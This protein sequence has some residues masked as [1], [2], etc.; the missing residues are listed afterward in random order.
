MSRRYSPNHPAVIAAR[1]RQDRGRV[2]RPGR[3]PHRT[4]MVTGV[5]FTVA[6]FL[7]IDSWWGLLSAALAAVFLA[8]SLAG[9]AD[10][11]DD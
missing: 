11:L 4:Y 7:L 6:A 2:T 5:L 8:P 9:W 10:T 1:Q 3:P